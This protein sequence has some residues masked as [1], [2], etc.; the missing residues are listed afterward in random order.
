M[1]IDQGAATRHRYR[2][3]LFDMDG[4]VLNSIA[5]AERIWAAWAARHGLDVEAFL[6][7]IHGA[8]SVDTVAKLDLPGVDPVAEAAAITQAEIDDVEGVVEIDGAAAF[9]RALPDDRWAIVTSA[10]LALAK[11]RLEAAGIPMPALLVTAEDVV[12]GKPS[13]DGYLLAARKLGVDAAECLIFED[14]TVGIRAA[15]SAG[16]TVMVVTTTHTHPMDTP[17]ATIEGYRALH[18]SMDEEGWIGLTPRQS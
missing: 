12:N 17:H 5:A 14:A 15:E 7:T 11:R 4:T 16:A 18:V 6:P 13:P 9:L 1:S 8:R 10:P 2:A 3:F